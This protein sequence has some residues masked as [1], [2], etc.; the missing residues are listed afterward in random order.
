MGMPDKTCVK[1]AVALADKHHS[2]LISTH[3]KN[4]LLRIQHD[5]DNELKT[6]L[7]N[8]R[9]ENRSAFSDVYWDKMTELVTS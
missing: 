5:V 6:I 1:D 2:L 3:N 8:L 4:V 7:K 9:V